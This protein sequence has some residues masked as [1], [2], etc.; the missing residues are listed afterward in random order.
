MK[1]NNPYDNKYGGDELYWG[2]E[3]SSLTKKLADYLNTQEHHL[4]TLID[5]G[6]GEGRNALFMAKT[7]FSVTGLDAAQAGLDTMMKIAAQSGTEITP[8]HGDVITY[9]LEQTY[10]IVFSTGTLHYLPQEI[11]TERF[12]HFKQNTPTEGLH[13]HSI[14]VEKPFVPKAPDAESSAHLFRSGELMSYYWDWEVIFSE[15]TIFDC[16]S[17]S[18]PHQ[19]AVNR[20]IARRPQ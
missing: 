2:T 4:S 16:N 13:A 9:R 3:P 8:I 19:H 20:I 6:C 7:G 15:E 17:G 1:S 18:V 12:D 14:F 5:L 11:R 10:D